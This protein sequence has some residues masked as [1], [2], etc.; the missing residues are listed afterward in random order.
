M[1]FAF[2]GNP[3]Q[4]TG[5]ACF[6]ASAAACIVAA[7]RRPRPWRSLAI[8]QAACFAEIL[9]GG[10]Y[11]VHGAVDDVLQ[12]AG[13]YPSRTPLQLGLLVVVAALTAIAVGVGWRAGRGD[14]P[15]RLATVATV[16]VVAQF[17]IET[18]SLH[19]VDSFMYAPV[20]PLLIGALGWIAAATVVTFA[21]LR[22][23]RA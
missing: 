5:L 23:A 11:L 13:W 14:T 21:A 22:A 1:G 2:D 20:G 7:R 9:F 15:A 8:A 19:D 6:A 17:T 4:W 3:T 18:V 16:V 12:A 10:R